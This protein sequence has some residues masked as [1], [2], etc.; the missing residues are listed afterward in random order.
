MRLDLLAEHPVLGPAQV[1]LMR[2]TP[3]TMDVLPLYVA[4]LAIL[5]AVLPLL[6][7]P[8]LLLGASAVVYLVGWRFDLNLP[9]W[10]GGGW[11]FDPLEWQVLFL[12]GVVLG[13]RARSGRANALSIPRWLVVWS[14]VFLVATRGIQLLQSKPEIAAHL[15]VLD[16]AAHALQPFFPIADGKVWLHPLR[17]VSVLA[18]AVV[19]R[20]AV[21]VDAPWLKSWPASP[22]TLMGQHSLTVFCAGVPLSFLTRVVLQQSSSLATLFVVNAVGFAMIVAVAWIAAR[23]GQRRNTVSRSIVPLKVASDGG[24]NV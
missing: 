14:L 20:A 2:F 22:F 4:L 11:G 9:T 10:D 6:K 19:F 23:L 24:A 12:V 15:S 13:D 16:A 8:F 5:A 17:L 7:R 1:F 18:L 3:Y 21:A